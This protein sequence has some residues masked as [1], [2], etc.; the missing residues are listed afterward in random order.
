MD[1]LANHKNYEPMDKQDILIIVHRLANADPDYH[2]VVEI[3]KTLK[4]P[5]ISANQQAGIC[6][7]ALH[8]VKELSPERGAV[9]E[10]LTRENDRQAFFEPVGALS[11][12]CIVILLRTHIKYQRKSDGDWEFK[13]EHKP[14][15][16]KLVA[17]FLKKVCSFLPIKDSH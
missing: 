1:T 2:E 13:V 5:S 4:L 12:A 9:I 7:D 3:F 11:L 17:E 14:A 15:D 6:R 10:K 8:V 16:S